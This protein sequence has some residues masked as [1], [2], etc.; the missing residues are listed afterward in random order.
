[1]EIVIENIDKN[2]LNTF[3]PYLKSHYENVDGTYTIV[4]YANGFSM[5]HHR[6]YLNEAGNAPIYKDFVVLELSKG[7]VK[8]EIALQS[9]EFN[10]ITVM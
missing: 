4:I 1:M 2:L 7:R 3:R 10:K 6:V 9:N 5:E 8:Q